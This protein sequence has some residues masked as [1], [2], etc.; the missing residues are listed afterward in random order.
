MNASVGVVV[1]HWQGMSDTRECLDSLAAAGG[2]AWR[3]VVVV[4]GAG[5]FDVSAAQAAYPGVEV[6]NASLNE[7][8]GAACNRGLVALDDRE[9][10]VFLN[11]DVVVEPHTIARLADVLQRQPR[12]GVAGPAVTYYDNPSRIWSAGGF[13][14]PWLGYTRHHGFD[15]PAP[16]RTT[17]NID[18]INGCVIA[19]RRELAAEVGG[20][21]TAYFHY[22][23]DTDLSARVRKRGFTCTVTPDAVVRHKV[24]ASAGQRGSNRMNATQAYY[25]S[26]NRVVFVRRNFAGVRRLTALA[27]QPLLVLFEVVKDIRERNLSAAAARWLGLFAAALGRTGPRVTRT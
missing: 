1:V 24:S 6:I 8:Y 18:F 20:F 3:V 9:I 25:F 26:R 27:A 5:D 12:A 21:N 13:V 17:R 15:A 16:P 22:F 14:H 23:E 10:V 4:N 7:G 2:T 11:N 19:M